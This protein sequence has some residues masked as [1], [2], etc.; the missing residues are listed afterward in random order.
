MNRRYFCH[1][2]WIC[3]D[4]LDFKGCIRCISSLITKF[5]WTFVTC[6]S[7]YV[8]VYVYC[9]IYQHPG[10]SV[11]AWMSV[12]MTCLLFFVVFPVSDVLF[13]NRQPLLCRLQLSLSTKESWWSPWS[14]SHL[15]IQ[16]LRKSK[17]RL[18]LCFNLWLCF[19]L[20]F[21]LIF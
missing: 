8:C 14:I 5:I 11:E 17:A 4:C 12:G 18:S 13:L 3:L 9:L 6:S 20:Y 15:K 16:Q 19:F 21:G 1:H 7:V 10:F 2:P